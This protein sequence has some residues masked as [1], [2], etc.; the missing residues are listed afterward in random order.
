MRVAIHVTHLLGTGHLARALTL[1]RAFAEAGH[2]AHVISGGLPLPTADTRGI[3]FHQL[4][5][6]AADGT[7]FT[8]L[9]D[10][11]GVEAT[12]AYLEA[13][14]ERAGALVEE[15]APQ[16]LITE[17]FPFGRRVLKAEFLTVLNRAK[18]LSPRPRIFA[19]IRDILAPPSKPSKAAE[20][21]AI[22]A[23][24]Y[25]GG[26]LVH[27][28]PEILP[29]EASWPV[30]PALAE[31]LLYT[32]FVAPPPPEPHPRGA[33]KGEVLVSAGGGPVGHR[34]FEAAVRAADGR[35][36]WRLLVG[37][38]DR[39]EEIARLSREVGPGVFVEPARPDFRQMLA[40][41]AASV[42]MC[43]YN[44]AMDL[45]Q[46]GCPGVLVPFDDG[47]EVEQTLRARALARLPQF[48]L[49]ST[50]AL[51]GRALRETVEEVA[52]QPRSPANFRFDGARRTVEIVCR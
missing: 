21:E 15:I 23:A 40:H 41:A 24:F 7:N 14:R 34:L 35:R 51:S 22:L 2:E 36:P 42:S 25:D 45:L 10:D 8:R 30:T 49:L 28:D 16:A 18:K 50:D 9:L 12:P 31:R 52:G 33:G 27:S 37:G 19:S 43:G 48:R 44:T 13:R 32:G 39:A 6:L 1:A 3:H 4:P 5:P 17:L 26:V 46:T 38:A 29:L 20:T 47:G 11:T